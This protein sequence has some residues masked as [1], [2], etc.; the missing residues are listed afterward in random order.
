MVEEEKEKKK[1]CLLLWNAIALLLDVVQ[2][3]CFFCTSEHVKMTNRIRRLSF[4]PSVCRTVNLYK[5]ALYIFGKKRPDT[6]AKTVRLVLL[7]LR[8]N[9]S[10]LP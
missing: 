1:K 5:Y 3:V 6:R 10:F 2:Q 9:P 8:P 7:I 4:H